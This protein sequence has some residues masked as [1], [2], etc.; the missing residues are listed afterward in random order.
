ME[1]LEL[2]EEEFRNYLNKSEERTFLQTPE[3]GKLREKSGWTVSYLGVKNKGEVV[4][5]AMFTSIT[6][7]F[8]KKE[9]YAPRGL[10]LDYSNQ[11]LLAFFTENILAVA[12]YQCLL[13][14]CVKSFK[15][16]FLLYLFP[17]AC[18]I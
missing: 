14:I 7:H 6:R 1:F 10:L 2:T 3:I 9:F 17:A 4:A 5:A 15:S 18:K 13:C 8:G 11:E 12:T 16:C